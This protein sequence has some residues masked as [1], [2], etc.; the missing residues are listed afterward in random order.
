MDKNKT[1]GEALMLKACRRCEA[2]GTI[3]VASAPDD[4]NPEVCDDCAGNGY[5][6]VNALSVWDKEQLAY[7]NGLL[8]T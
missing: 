5:H 4:A 1:I 8:K 6:E 3:W 2:T 7:E